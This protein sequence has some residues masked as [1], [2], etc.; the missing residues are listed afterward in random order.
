MDPVTIA[1]AVTGA[2]QVGEYIAG[3]IA[4]YRAGQQPT[5]SEVA[6][7]QAYAEAHTAAVAADDAADARLTADLA[8]K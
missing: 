6:K 4:R 2:V 5:Q 1:A 8:G 3:V 7:L